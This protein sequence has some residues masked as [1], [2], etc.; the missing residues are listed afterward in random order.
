[1]T[2]TV[3]LVKVS[4]I[5]FTSVPQVYHC[6]TDRQIPLRAAARCIDIGM[7]TGTGTNT[8]VLQ[9]PHNALKTP[10]IQLVGRAASC[11]LVATARSHD[12]R[13]ADTELPTS[14]M[15]SYVGSLHC[16]KWHRLTQRGIGSFAVL[17]AD[18][19]AMGTPPP[20]AGVGPRAPTAA[21]SRPTPQPG[22]CGCGWCSGRIACAPPGSS[23]AQP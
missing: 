9:L 14:N 15:G 11:W 5:G 16:P 10:L 13:L 6:C 23:W 4:S 19:T 21:S 12:A 1:M 22:S 2:E 17:I 7:G 3:L 20:G 18:L 8:A